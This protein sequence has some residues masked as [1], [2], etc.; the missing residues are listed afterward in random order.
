MSASAITVSVA[1]FVH[2]LKQKYPQYA[3]VPD[4][5]LVAGFLSKNPRYKGNYQEGALVSA[6]GT[7]VDSFEYGE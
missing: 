1:Q 5:K 3:S 6:F 4:D 2:Q 7:S